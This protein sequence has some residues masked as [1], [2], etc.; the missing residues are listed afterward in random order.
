MSVSPNDGSSLTSKLLL[1]QNIHPASE[2]ETHRE[3]ILVLS[4]V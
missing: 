4:E 1:R 3:R 2:L